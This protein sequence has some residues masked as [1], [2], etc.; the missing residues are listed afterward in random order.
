MLLTLNI[1]TSNRS[2]PVM[3]G[4][5]P[6]ARLAGWKSEQD[7]TLSAVTTNRR[8]AS[9]SKDP[10]GGGADTTCSGFRAPARSAARVTCAHQAN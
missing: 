9:T 2:S 5:S 7:R 10:A 6:T 1:A 4:Q 3:T 8:S